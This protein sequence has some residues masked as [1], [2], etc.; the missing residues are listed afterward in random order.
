MSGQVVREI[1]RHSFDF[2]QT[3][4]YNNITMGCTFAHCFACSYP[5]KSCAPAQYRGGSN[6]VIEVWKHY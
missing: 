3:D 1:R 2:T 5:L 4:H 6:G